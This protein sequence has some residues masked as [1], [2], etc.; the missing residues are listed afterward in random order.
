MKEKNAITFPSEHSMEMEAGFGIL[1]ELI[2]LLEVDPAMYDHCM[3]VFLFMDVEAE[4]A[5]T[6]IEYI[7]SVTKLKVARELNHY[8]R[9]SN[10]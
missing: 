5:K 4:I 2:L 7:C 3:R 1:D 10:R 9:R 6:R 8:H